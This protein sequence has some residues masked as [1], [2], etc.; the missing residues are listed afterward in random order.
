M[1][2]PH[3]TALNI[4]T[5]RFWENVQKTETCWF[6]IGSKFSNGYGSIR[7]GF[8]RKSPRTTAHRIAWEI[9]FGLV[10]DGLFVCHRCDVKHCVNP[11]HLFVGTQ[12][13]NVSDM[14]AKGRDYFDFPRKGVNNGELNGASTPT[15]NDVREIRHRYKDE[16]LDQPTLAAE[17]NVSRQAIGLIVNNKRWVE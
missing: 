4:R 10:P 2:I 9:H 14:I 8:G 1:F 16:T 13:D 11:S 6:W 5:A 12:Y 3:E 15:Q 17:F 7:C